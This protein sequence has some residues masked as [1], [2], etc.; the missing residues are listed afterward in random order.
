AGEFGAVHGLVIVR[1]GYVVTDEYFGGWKRDSIHTMQSVTKSV[2]SLVAGIAIDRGFLRGTDQRMVD[3]LAAYAPVAN[4]DARKQAMTVR[5]VLTMGTGLDWNEDV[6]AGSP[7]E[8]LNTS[9]SDW[10]RFVIDWPMGSAPGTAWQY[11]SGG[12]IALGGAIGL[13]A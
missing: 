1:K 8:K 2:T 4:L 11:N 3:L 5:D 13:A 12:V 6:Y 7:L 9:Q 10:L